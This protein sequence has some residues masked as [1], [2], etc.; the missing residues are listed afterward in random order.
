MTEHQA[1]TT[2]VKVQESIKID[3]KSQDGHKNPL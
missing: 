1:R 3:S 2:N